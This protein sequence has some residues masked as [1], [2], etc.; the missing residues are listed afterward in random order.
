MNVLFRTKIAIRF[1]ICI[2]HGTRRI[3][4]AQWN[5]KQTTQTWLSFSNGNDDTKQ[6]SIVRVA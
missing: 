3:E 5:V 6:G 2:L 1:Y 4:L